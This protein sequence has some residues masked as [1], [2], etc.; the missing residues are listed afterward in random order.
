MEREACT[1]GSAA[2]PSK[3][4]QASAAWR[5]FELSSIVNFEF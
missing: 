2:R 4:S 3:Q 1:V 5:C